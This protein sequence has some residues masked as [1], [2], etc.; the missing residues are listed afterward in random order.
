L[1]L[2]FLSAPQTLSSFSSFLVHLLH[3]KVDRGVQSQAA[4]VRAKGRVELHPVAAVD[5]QIA[6]IV[7]PD[8]TELNDALRDRGDL[9]GGPVLGELLEERAVLKRVGELCEKPASARRRSPSGN[10]YLTHP[11]TPARTQAQKEGSTS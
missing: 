1:R 5:L 9:E 6:G 4:L 11:C 2:I 10:V 8:D 3:R 7:F